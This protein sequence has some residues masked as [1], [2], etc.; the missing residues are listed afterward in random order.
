ML[1]KEVFTDTILQNL[2]E[3]GLNRLFDPVSFAASIGAGLFEP[4]F[5]R[6][7]NRANLAV[8]REE[9]QAAIL[10]FQNTLLRPGR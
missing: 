5:N 1:F 7:L 9:L 3:K 4:I 8:T 6:G 2:I 10:S